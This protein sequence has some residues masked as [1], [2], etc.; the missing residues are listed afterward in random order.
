[1]ASPVM[2]TEFFLE[3]KKKYA[4]IVYK[5]R[6][7][8]AVQ[9]AVGLLAQDLPVRAAGQ[10]GAEIAQFQARYRAQPRVFLAY[11]RQAFSGAQDTGLRVTFDTNLRWRQ[12]ELDLRLG[13]HGAPLLPPDD[14]LLEIKLPG[15]CPLWLSIC[16]R[17]R[18]FSPPRF[19]NM[20]PATDRSLQRRRCAVFDSILGQSLTPPTFLICTGVSLA[21]GVVL[22]LAS[23]FRART[24]QSFGLTLAVLPAVVQ[25]VIMLVNGNLG[26]GVAVAGAFSLVRFRSIPGTAREI[27]VLFLAMAP[28]LATGMGYL[29]IAVLACLLLTS[30]LLLFT[31]LGFGQDRAAVRTL[32]VPIPENLDYDGL[33]D[34]LFAQYTRAWRLNRVKTANMGTLFSLEYEIILPNDI[35][36]KAFPDAIR[37]RNGN[38]DVLCSR[39]LPR[40]I[41]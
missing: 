28:G 16:S 20:A 31:A 1:M 11:D 14:V 21:L 6:I 33:F 4:G 22:A 2:G 23:S 38:L 15:T 39:P 30:F 37:C 29:G 27:A 8:A 7:T 24:S 41:L 5:R 10:I 36:P 25:L 3:I 40:E 13:D 17:R 26:A 35:P 34:D 12:I 19:P 9:D 18:A 32:K